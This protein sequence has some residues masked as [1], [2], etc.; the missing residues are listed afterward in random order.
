MDQHNSVRILHQNL[1]DLN[2]I[3]DHMLQEYTHKNNIIKNG[4]VEKEQYR[5]HVRTMKGGDLSCGLCGMKGGNSITKDD[6][7]N[8]RGGNFITKDN[9]VNS[10]GGNSITKDDRVNPRGGDA[11][12]SFCGMNGGY[13]KKNEK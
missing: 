12:C 13:R 1:S 5:K 3:A 4:I 11:G 2:Q 8:P 9:R 6:R 7:V 10:R